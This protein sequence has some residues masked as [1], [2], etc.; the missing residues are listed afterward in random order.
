MFDMES[1]LH[2][3][4]VVFS[5]WHLP[6]SYSIPLLLLEYKFL[7]Q[8]LFVSCS[9]LP[10]YVF[11][12]VYLWPSGAGDPL[13]LSHQD[14]KGMVS[15]PP[16]RGLH[17]GLANKHQLLQLPWGEMLLHSFPTRFWL[18]TINT[19]QYLV[20]HAVLPKL[21][22]LTEEAEA[23]VCS[24]QC[25]TKEFLETQGYFTFSFVFQSHFKTNQ[26]N[27]TSRKSSSWAI[28]RQERC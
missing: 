22:G 11:S 1:T 26:C 2:H 12:G 24:S 18:D 9:F 21:K 10:A 15:L 3:L 23:N 17:A 14:G 8:S 5:C 27:Y 20:C 4:F 6:L 13:A 7:M 28:K 19:N 25:R 16:S